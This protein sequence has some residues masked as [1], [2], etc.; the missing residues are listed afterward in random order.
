MLIEQHTVIIYNIMHA[1]AQVMSST[2]VLESKIILATIE[3]VSS[4][5]LL[6]N[7]YS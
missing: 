7:F 3:I 2:H 6:F 4:P 1:H 5:D